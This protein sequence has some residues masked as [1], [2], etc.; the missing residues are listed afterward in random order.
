MTAEPKRASEWT[1]HGE[2]VIDDS[3]RAVL[4]IA[5]VELP[6]G[7][8]FEQYVLRVPGA[9]MVIVVDDDE[10]VLMMWRHR[11]IVDRWVWELPGGYL[12]PAE[13]AMACATREVEEETGWR[14]RHLEKLVTFQPMVGTID[15]ENVVYIARGADYIGSAPDINEAERLGWIPLDQVQELTDAGAIVGAG[16]ISGLLAVL[17]LKATGKL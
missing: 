15:Q 6:D 1:I 12:D 8:R 7:V 3:R 14:P 13:D 17:L 9:A 10:R 16:S 2:R 11:F 5:D 4:S